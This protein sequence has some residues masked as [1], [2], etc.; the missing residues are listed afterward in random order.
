[1]PPMKD[2]TGKKFGD[3]LDWYENVYKK[4]KKKLINKSYI[5]LMWRMDW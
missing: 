2:L 5:D 4:T 1:M 3:F